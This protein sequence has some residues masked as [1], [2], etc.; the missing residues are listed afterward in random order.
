[1]QL[2]NASDMNKINPNIKRAFLI[3]MY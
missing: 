1:M 2:A 3:M